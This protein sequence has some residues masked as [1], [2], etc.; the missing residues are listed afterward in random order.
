MADNVNPNQN[1]TT[2]SPLSEVQYRLL[3]EQAVDGMFL[4]DGKGRLIAVNVELS[5][6]CDF[7]RD[8]LT[9][10]QLASL[11]H[12]D[13]PDRVSMPLAL[14]E[15]GQ[16]VAMEHRLL[17]KDGVAIWVALRM[18]MTATGDIVG[19][20]TDIDERRQSTFRL[21]QQQREQAALAAMTTATSF[22]LSPRQIASAA[23]RCLL[24]ATAA[25][26]VFLFLRDGERLV[27]FEL[28][29]AGAPLPTAAAANEHR[30][31]E[32]LCGMAAR[33]GQPLY[34]N[35]IQGDPRCTREECKRAG[36]RSFAALP[37][38]NNETVIGTIGLA[39]QRPRDFSL[40]A[41]FLS[42]MTRQV[43]LALT[44]AQLYQT[45]QQELAERKQAEQQLLLS[46]FAADHAADAIYWL[47]SDARIFYVNEAAC[48]S[49]GYSRQELQTMTVHDIDPGFPAEVWRQSWE[50]LKRLKTQQVETMHRRKDG[51]CF[52]VEIKAAYLAFGDQEYN[53]AFVRD[54]SQ[55]KQAEQALRESESLFSQVFSLSPAPMVISEVETGRFIDA[56]EQWLR[57]VGFKR[58]ETIDR[59]SYALDIWEDPKVRATIAER[60]KEKGFIREE[61]IRFRTKAGGI[62]ETLWSAVLV[63]MGGTRVM[64][65]LIY[66]FT[67]RKR[68]EEALRFTQFAIDK[69]ADQIFWINEAG[70]FTYAN[71]QACQVLGYSRDELLRMTVH[72]IDPSFNPTVRVN[73]RSRLKEHRFLVLETTHRNRQG[74]VYPVEVRSNY[75]EYEGQAFN[76]C[77]VQDIT[78]R[79]EAEAVLREKT[80]ELDRFFTVTLDL[81]C[82]CDLHGNLIR[83]NPQWEKVLG[84]A[85]EELMGAPFLQFV[86]PED[87]EATLATFRLAGQRPIIDFANRYRCKDGSYRSLEWRSVPSGN[88]IY[89]AARDVTD[90]RRVEQ[91]EAANRAKSRF[92]ANMSHEIRTPMNAILGLTHLALESSDP[93][94]Q[95][96]LLQTVQQ[97]A[98]SLLGILND[99]LDFSKIE[100]GQLQFER[101]SF[102]LDQ[103]LENIASIM[104]VQA[105]E[106]GIQFRVSLESGLPPAVV[107]DDLRLRQIL[108]NLVNNAIKYTHQG[109]VTLHL[110]PA[111]EQPAEGEARLH[112][113]VTDTGIGI[114]QDKLE[115]I[116]NS[117]EQADS[118]YARKYGGT[119]LGLAICRHLTERMGGH[120]WVESELGV[121]STF[122][123]VLDLPCSNLESIDNAGQD[124]PL[125]G[126]D[127]PANLRILVVDD[128]EVNRD[129]ASMML[130][131]KHRVL[132]AA[133]GLDA[134]ELL[135]RHPIELVLMDVQMPV[136]DG[137]ATTR[138]IRALEENQTLPPDMPKELAS[139]LRGLLHG[140]H[141]PIVAMTAHALGDDRTMCLQAGMDYYITKPFQPQQLS[142]MLQALA[143][144]LP[145]KSS[146]PPKASP[147]GVQERMTASVGQVTHF[148]QAATGLPDEAI[149]RILDSV[150]QSLNDNLNRMA[151]ALAADDQPTL[152]TAAHTLKGVLLQCGLTELAEMAEAMR[153]H[154]LSAADFSHGETLRSIGSGLAA[155]LAPLDR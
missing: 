11:L 82:L 123:V 29:S 30:V 2:T 106:K 49:L 5:E 36:I 142:N 155:L 34:A 22:S 35:D 133:N 45:V 147:D 137:L 121:G 127:A 47:T 13:D 25:D 105:A 150:R 113:S 17:R 136:M 10:R 100:A 141:L 95:R 90:R 19:L 52:P 42:I 76:C 24:E 87:R 58:E 3:F 81:F 84:Y 134:L 128:N 107:G 74:R 23:S 9:G 93:A 43:A 41:Q 108:L 14:P 21:E 73:F 92:L 98:E 50:E 148:L 8:E 18:R 20:M 110:A 40:Q 103:V 122:H 130:A 56:N 64:L 102:R 152:A 99:I 153:T 126:Q 124:D 60:L 38:E 12:P 88:R 116:F 140:R 15:R 119:G 89:A 63:T 149:D 94:Q 117:F 39:S 135:R 151:N 118:S 138:I 111:A 86:H 154:P 4:A 51:A 139:E 54:I 28:V 85:H 109:S 104:H 91:A 57:M 16:V 125:A 48:Q 83:L 62:K 71:D 69:S 70:R 65:S 26:L 27:L 59:T 79:K 31:G 67:E 115:D 75:L 120:L 72:D 143:I 145:R 37:L 68:A 131:K 44:N 32:C 53:L 114:A 80:E 77:F 66:D 46:Q 144:M 101:R 97:S 61:P 146:G 112:F 78:K 55:R 1:T 33:E 129:V 132:T 6:L 96:R 7:S